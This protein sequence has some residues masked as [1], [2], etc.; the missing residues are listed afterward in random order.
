MSP[1]LTLSVTQHFKAF[2]IVRLFGVG[3]TGGFVTSIPTNLAGGQGGSQNPLLVNHTPPEAP[4]GHYSHVDAACRPPKLKTGT[5]IER[6]KTI[7]DCG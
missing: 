5:V 6:Q 4:Y 2:N 1:N 7:V 3:G